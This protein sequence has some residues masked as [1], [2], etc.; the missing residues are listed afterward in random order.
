[1]LHIRPKMFSVRLGS[2][3]SPLGLIRG[4]WPNGKCHPSLSPRSSVLDRD[5][6]HFALVL[7]YLRH[8][9]NHV[10]P[11]RPPLGRR[12]GMHWAFRGWR[13]LA[14]TWFGCHRV[15][16][17]ESGRDAPLIMIITSS[18]HTGY[19]HTDRATGAL[20]TV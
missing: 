15:R 13:L 8:G 4:V 9:Q 17:T 3:P 2:D 7:A 5:P 18:G 11:A 16:H 14:S 20:R 1:V 12:G 19:E 10:D 6:A